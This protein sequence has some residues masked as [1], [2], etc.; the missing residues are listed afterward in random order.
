MIILV[1]VGILLVSVVLAGG[2]LSALGEV[3]VRWLPALLVAF[4]LQVVALRLVPEWP[5]GLLAVLHVA[6]YGAGG[7]FV[8][9]NRRIP[10][11]WLIALGGFANFAAIAANGGVMPASPAAMSAAGVTPT[12]G[13][14]V[15]SAPMEDPALWFLG[16]IFAIPAGWPLANVF[17]IG[18]VL[19]VLGA[20]LGII[21]MLAEQ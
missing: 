2:R 6:S 11:L 18:D 19:I 14:F 7:A 15:N 12:E 4:A 16:D 20:A 17:S 1:L 13:V 10:G 21:L 8:V 9:V 5:A 3:R